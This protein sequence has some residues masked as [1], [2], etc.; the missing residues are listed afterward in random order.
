[1]VVKENGN[2]LILIPDAFE[3]IFT[4][5]IIVAPFS[6][7]AIWIVFATAS[8][9]IVE[10]L[11]AIVAI[12][13]VGW[14][15]LLV[16]S[17]ECAYYTV[18]DKDTQ[19]IT[20]TLRYS[21]YLWFPRTRKLHFEKLAALVLHNKDNNEDR[22]LTLSL[23]L[24]SG[25][26]IPFAGTASVKCAEQVSKFL[27]I[28]LKINVEG[29]TITHMPWVSDKESTLFPTPCA[30]CGAPLPHIEPGMYNVKCS[31]CG[32]TMVITWSEGK[33]SYKALKEVP[34]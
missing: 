9:S 25:T 30:K 21:V 28:P 27:R 20:F 33:I 29:E 13:I 6:L 14:F 32:M 31:H 4:R 26:E 7:V 22:K 18:F 3:A 15:I 11:V 8:K 1:M 16:L 24:K 19:K 34:G 2:Q 23:R 12:V 17:D 10:A 5:L